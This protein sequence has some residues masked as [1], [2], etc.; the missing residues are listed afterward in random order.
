M[1]SHTL[2][3][4]KQVISVVSDNICFVVFTGFSFTSFAR[5]LTVSIFLHFMFNIYRT[6]SRF[7]L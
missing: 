4:A 2:K 7:R 3:V 5:D 1:N 6:L